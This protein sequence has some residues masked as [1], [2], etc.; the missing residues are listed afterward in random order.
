[1]RRVKYDLLTQSLYY[2]SRIQL[3]HGTS[4]KPSE[5]RILSGQTQTTATIHMYHFGNK[6][7]ARPCLHTSIPVLSGS[8]RMYWQQQTFSCTFGRYVTHLPLRITGVDY[9]SRQTYPRPESPE[10]RV[11]TS[12]PL[13]QS[14]SSV[15]WTSCNALSGTQPRKEPACMSDRVLVK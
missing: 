8:A 6:S 3:L 11:T 14:F 5:Q 9:S 10:T 15:G 2:H 1:M 7:D 13:Q 12:R 4:T